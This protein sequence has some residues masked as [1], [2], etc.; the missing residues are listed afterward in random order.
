[1]FRMSRPS[2]GSSPTP[3]T[4]DGA[5]LLALDRGIATAWY[6]Y[7]RRPELPRSS[8]SG[9][10][11][12]PAS[13]SASTASTSS[14]RPCSRTAPSASQGPVADRRR[15]CHRRVLRQRSAKA[16]GLVSRIVRRFQTGF[17]YQYA[18]TMIIGLVLLLSLWLVRSGAS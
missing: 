2:T 5:P 12:S 6:L 13:W 14:I 7:I 10:G 16:V 4:D 1:M 18:F 15:A 9:P 17:I 8:A 3:C 11:C